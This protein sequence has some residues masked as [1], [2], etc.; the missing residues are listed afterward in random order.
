MPFQ[1]ITLLFLMITLFSQHQTIAQ[2]CN[3]LATCSQCLSR[4]ATCGW[5][6]DMSVFTRLVN[7]TTRHLQPLS[8]CGT[9]DELKVINCPSIS[10][11]DPQGSITDDS[12]DLFN[13]GMVDDLE[14]AV[15]VIP[16]HANVHV[17]PGITRDFKVTV[18]PPDFISVDMYILMDLSFTMRNDRNNLRD[19]SDQIIDVM[20]NLT[21]QFRIGFGSFIDKPVSPFF[22]RTNVDHACADLSPEE[23]K[24]VCEPTYAFKH[25]LDFTDDPDIFKAEVNNSKLSGSLDNP[26]STLDAILQIAVCQDEIGWGEIGNARRLILIMTDGDY[27]IALDGKVCLT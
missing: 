13:Q 5:C 14:Q 12:N 15:P 22:D 1:A 4:N 10:I 27:H 25:H 20:S 9:P 3:Q 21:D 8:L 19:L 16:L 11:I 7:S 26:E 6:N 17:R 23:N 2:E 18:Q 24:A